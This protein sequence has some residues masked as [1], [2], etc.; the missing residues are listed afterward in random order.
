MAQMNVSQNRLTDT[1]NRPVAAKET[2]RGG[3][4]WE[5]RVSRGKLFHSAWINGKVL[6]SST[7]HQ[8]QTPGINYNGK[9]I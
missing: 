2:G 8:I 9:R 4:D 3:T 5:F 1:E 6:L 7:G